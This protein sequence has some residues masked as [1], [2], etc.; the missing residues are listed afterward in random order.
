MRMS[1]YSAI[2]DGL[3]P[4]AGRGLQNNALVIRSVRE[5]WTR[6]P[7]DPSR[8]FIPAQPMNGHDIRLC[9]RSFV[10]NPSNRTFHLPRS[11]ARH[12]NQHHRLGDPQAPRNP[13]ERPQTPPTEPRE[14]ENARRCSRRRRG[15]SR[16]RSSAGRPSPPRRCAG[17]PRRRARPPP[18]SGSGSR[19]TGTRWSTRRRSWTARPTT[20]S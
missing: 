20:S 17:T 14:R 8:D 9:N 19:R 1:S 4:S 2:C 3:K 5:M 10:S 6:R 12:D 13:I 11:R 15:T 16:G 7:D 18:G